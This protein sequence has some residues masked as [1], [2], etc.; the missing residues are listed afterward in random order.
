MTALADLHAFDFAHADVTVWVFKKSGGLAGTVPSFNGKWLATDQALDQKL[1]DTARAV[2]DGVGETHAYDLL[3]QT[4]EASAL[5]IGR[6]ET[7]APLAIAAMGDPTPARR[8][9]ALN[10]LNNAVFYVVKFVHGD[11]PLYAFSKTD[12]SWR[13]MKSVS[14]TS[15]LFAGAVLTLDDRPRFTISDRFDFFVLGDEILILSKGGF[16]SILNYKQAHVDD[17]ASL[18]EEPEFAAVFSDLTE[19]IG[20]VG[21]NKIQL[22]RTSAIKTK[23][24]YKDPDYMNRLRAEAHSLGFAITFDAAGRIIP[25]PNNCRDIIQALL[26]H[27]LD[28]RL[29]QRLYDVESTEI[30]NP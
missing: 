21:S 14:V 30:V 17:F 12:G 4:N 13:S 26:D 6:D 24:H 7:Y 9:T 8:A 19:L 29:S 2:G 11:V 5:S 27:R 1:K 18:Q 28:S 20:F 23:G 22:R 16:E 10:E 3:A 25:T 15:V